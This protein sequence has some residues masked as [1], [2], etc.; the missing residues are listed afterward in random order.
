MEEQELVLGI[1]L[2]FGPSWMVERFLLRRLLEGEAGS[3]LL[4][5]VAELRRTSDLTEMVRDM[6]LLRSGSSTE[7]LTQT[8]Q[9]HVFITPSMGDSPCHHGHDQI[10]CSRHSSFRLVGDKYHLW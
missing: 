1:V 8:Y 4:G 10:N 2:G 5:R 3:K 6:V 7:G 9:F